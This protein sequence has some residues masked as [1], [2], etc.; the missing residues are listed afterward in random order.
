MRAVIVDRYQIGYQNDEA[1]RSGALY[2]YQRLGFR[3]TDPAA[4]RLLEE[5]QVKVARDPRIAHQARSQAPRSLRSRPEL[6]PRRAAR[7]VRPGA[8]AAAVSD[9]VARHYAGDR[10]TAVRAAMARVGRILGGWP[11]RGTSPSARAALETFALVLDLVP[12]LAAV[13][14]RPIVGR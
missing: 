4:R 14:E 10:A 8:L 11:K 3:P 9:H 5:E 1:L 7:R 2:F 13:A 12:D 6:D